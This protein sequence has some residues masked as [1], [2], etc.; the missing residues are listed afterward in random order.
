MNIKEILN[1]WSFLGNYEIK[2]AKDGTNNSL[3]FVDSQG[4]Q[5]I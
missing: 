1:L 2:A 3:Y 5:F 4:G